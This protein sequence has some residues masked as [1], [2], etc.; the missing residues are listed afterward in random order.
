MSL[1]QPPER[2][3]QPGRGPVRAAPA[4]ALPFTAPTRAALIGVIVCSAILSRFGVSIGEYSVSFSLFCQYA[5]LA[6]LAASGQLRTDVPRAV[7]YAGL[8]LVAMLSW[9]F[10]MLISSP[11]SLL[12]LM[13]IYLPFAFSVSVRSDV[14]EQ[15]RWMIGVFRS[16]AL[17]CAVTGIIQF[18]AQFV[19]HEPW[20]F[21]WTEFI[22]K[23]LRAM[24]GY[25]TA[26]PVGALFKSNGF[27]FR[28]PSGFSQF[29]AFGLICEMSLKERWSTAKF[30]RMGLFGFG[31]LLSYSGTGILTLLIGM[32]F[33]LGRKT[34]LRVAALAVAGVL[35]VTVLG[36][37]LNLSFTVGRIYEFSSDRSSGYSRFVAPVRLILENLSGDPWTPFLGNGPGTITRVQT[38]YLKFDPTYAKSIFEYGLAGFFFVI[39]LVLYACNQFRSPAEL[40]AA[41][42]ASYLIMGG[43]LLAPD[44]TSLIYV[45]LGLW[46]HLPALAPSS[47]QHAQESGHLPYG[48]RVAPHGS[49]G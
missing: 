9:L 44:E 32:L 6:S 31:L 21:D 18:C 49:S 22:P 20:L 40:R 43:H 26:I 35:V 37:A 45:L 42:L 19:I 7:L 11:T 48:E 46:P 13:T 47:R 24:A 33:P 15:W 4:G 23:P 29:M 1:L 28:E 14:G 2:D 8:L 3:H 5:A 12:L 39:G 16:V 41:L 25:N 27:F 38:G 34:L 17:F 36:E 30:V 10:N